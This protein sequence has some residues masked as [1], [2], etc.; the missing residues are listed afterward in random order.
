[1]KNASVSVLLFLSLFFCGM[2][3]A[4]QGNWQIGGPP[5]LNQP[6]TQSMPSQGNRTIRPQQNH[7]VD[8]EV[9]FLK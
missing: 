8:L 7:T 5:F 6:G 1:M 3:K 9:F 2:V 4:Q